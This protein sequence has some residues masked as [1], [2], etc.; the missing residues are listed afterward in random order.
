MIS[1]E[2]FQAAKDELRAAIATF[3]EKTAPDVY[4]SA[5]VLV[6]HKESIELEQS[7]SSA[8]GVLIATG[9]AFPMTRGMLEVALDA[10]RTGHHLEP[11][12]I[13][14]ESEE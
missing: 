1:D 6:T 9:Q 5:W 11:A 8:V 14:D 10:E 4:V 12:T 13:D 7:G 3:Y 2:D